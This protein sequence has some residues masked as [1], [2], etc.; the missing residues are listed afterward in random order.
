ML[1][2]QVVVDVWYFQPV[3]F[4]CISLPIMPE[5]RFVN[6]GLMGKWVFVAFI[7][8]IQ[9]SCRDQLLFRHRTV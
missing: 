6:F 4:L 9:K 3:H 7:N 1:V 8:G 2:K 5:L